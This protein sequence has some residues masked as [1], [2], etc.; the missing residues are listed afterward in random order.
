MS[1]RRLSSVTWTMTVLMA[2]VLLFTWGCGS[3][4]KSQATQDNAKQEI[5]G[6]IRAGITPTYPPL[7][8]LKN[9]KVSGIE[10]DFAEA[11]SAELKTPVVFVEKP[12]PELINSLV[13]GE[14][15]MIM[16]GMSVTAKREA[17]VR[18]VM[19]YMHVGQMAIIRKRDSQRFAQPKEAIYINGLRVGYQKGTTGLAFA[20]EKLLLA[21]LVKFDSAGAGLE[22]LQNSGIEVFIH[23]SPTAWQIHDNPKYSDLMA[24]TAPL[25]REP[26]AWAVR[27]DDKSLADRLNAILGAWK[28]NGRLDE[29]IGRW[30]PVSLIMK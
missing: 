19:P 4:Q 14:I 29:I 16:S 8:F 25:T 3:V 11:L 22:S 13:K 5:Q 23:D 24:V 2:G 12:F 17:Q 21:E 9:G 18:F 10:A 26:L 20:A 6:P 1:K 27:K 15:D 30:V 28:K 7:I